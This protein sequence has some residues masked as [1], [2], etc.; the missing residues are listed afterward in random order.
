MGERQ[1]VEIAKALGRRVR[2]LVLDEP[3]AA[4]SHAETERLMHILR[5]FRTR[6]MAILFVSHHLDDVFQ[7]ADKISVL[8]DGQRVGTWR[9]SELTMPELIAA[10]V[11]ETV[12][13]GR[14]SRRPTSGA[15]LLR[16]RDAQGS[17]F[18]GVSLDARDG[19]ILGLT[20][21]AGAGHEELSAAVCGA[22]PFDAGQVLWKHQPHQ[23]HHPADALRAGIAF[24]PADRRGEGLVLTRGIME[25]LTL[26]SLRELAVAGWIRQR[27]RQKSAQLW[28]QRLQIRP[29]R[30]SQR[31][32]TLSG[33]NQQKVLLARGAALEPELFVLN[34]PTRGVDVKTR[35][36]IHRWIEDLAS[37]GSCVL[38]VSSDTQ[39]IIRLADRCLVFRD[40]R[41]VRELQYVQLDEHA[42]VAAMTGD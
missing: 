23:P 28:C 22:A 31:V 40:G 34:E 41:I 27:A 32:S 3:T 13:I 29:N 30:L 9:A 7:I 39:E 15:P 11:G 10:M 6:G 42:L 14:R 38:L 33:G 19:E 36:A 8:R 20:G 16:L 1:Q 2:I 25:N 5:A 37:A 35:E 4:L 18:R 17:R 12:E 21:L 24:V 26:A